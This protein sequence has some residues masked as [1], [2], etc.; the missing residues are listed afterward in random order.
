MVARACPDGVPYRKLGEIGKFYGGITGK[1]KDDFK[2]GNAKFITYMNV[3][4]NP[5]LRLDLDDKVRIGKN[6]K[7]RTLQY[8]DVLFTG[9]SETP[10]ECGISSVVT[11]QPTEDLYLNSFCFFLRLNDPKLIDP[12]FAKHLFRCD[13]LRRQI[14]K[15][16]NGV[17]RYN[18]SK[19]L[20]ENVTIPLPP[21]D[22]QR[23]VVRILDEFSELTESLT[24]GLH[25]EIAARQKQY[26]YYRDKLL[27]FKRKG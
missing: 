21:L 15:T 1:S 13:D 4:K 16:A 12:D 2:D 10:D 26:E 11:E 14:G 19:K 5:A 6:E 24:S 8:G 17:T 22:V 3:Y 9:S 7:Q 27:S 23:E 18:V 25:A 20:M